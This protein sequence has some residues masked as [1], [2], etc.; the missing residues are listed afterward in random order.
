MYDRRTQFE[1]C[2][3]G[4]A[5]VKGR[6]VSNWLAGQSR[7]SRSF[8][9]SAGGR[10]LRRIESCGK[11]LL[12]QEAPVSS[13]S[14]QFCRQCS[15]LWAGWSMEGEAARISYLYAGGWRKASSLSEGLALTQLVPEFPLANLDGMVAVAAL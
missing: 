12:N 11:R 4:R 8:A 6:Q 5:A 7:A 1:V 9:I 3:Q 14:L 13:H 15:A 2:N 10:G